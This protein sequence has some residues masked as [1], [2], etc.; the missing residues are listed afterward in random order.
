MSL[1]I[2]P[3]TD[4]TVWDQF[5]VVEKPD[6][7]LQSYTWGEFQADKIERIGVWS[8]NDLVGVAL[9]I[10]TEAKR[11]KFILC[12]HGPIIKA[13]NN[14]VLDKLLEYMVELGK[15]VKADFIRVAPLFPDQ[16]DVKDC[17][18]KEGF[19]RAPIHVHP[20]LSWILDITP[21]DEIL[22]KNMRKTTRYSIRKAEKDGV[23]VRI[24]TNQADIAVFHKLYLT[25]V[26]R[27]GFQPF[28]LEYL[29]REF[30][31]FNQTDMVRIGIAEEQGV[32]VAGAIIILTPYE[33]FYHQGASSHINPKS[34]AAYLLQWRMIQEAKQHGCTKYNFWGISPDDKP[35]H[36]WAGLSLFKKGF[37]GQAYQ[38][39]PTQDRPLT[40][41]YWLNW[42]L[43]TTRRKRRGYD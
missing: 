24:S 18:I 15:K 3:I 37:G 13:H 30:T 34:T 20:E 41:K 8:E 2:K 10:I 39:L 36:P 38:Y 40:L 27:Q 21:D 12:P 43:E 14:L 1:T 9:L 25:T 28:S 33:A 31:T 19:R 6:T 5:I 22:M 42:L 16:P 23:T 26:A 32:A 17:F 4:Q 11:G 7:F 35:N 29:E